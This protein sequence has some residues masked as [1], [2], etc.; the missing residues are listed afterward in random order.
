MYDGHMYDRVIPPGHM[1][2]GTA[3]RMTAPDVPGHTCDGH[4][5]D[6]I[7]PAGHMYDGMTVIHVT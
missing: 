2:D 7:F 1:Y 4:M 6:G 3:T 5:Y